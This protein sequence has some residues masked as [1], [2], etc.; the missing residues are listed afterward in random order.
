VK[1]GF[2]S[3]HPATK[4][5]GL[6]KRFSAKGKAPMKKLL[7]LATLAAASVLVQTGASEAVVC[8]RGV[9]RAGCA[10]PNG[11][12]GVARPAYG[13]AVVRPGYGAAVVRPAP[14]VGVY[15]RW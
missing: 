8:A 5:S 13:A 14:R 11:A 7:V 10:G 4:I 1:T 3:S 12:V 6:T 9:Y 15:R 2:I